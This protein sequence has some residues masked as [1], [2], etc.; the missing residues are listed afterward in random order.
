MTE[1]NKKLHSYLLSNIDQ[2]DVDFVIPRLGVDIP[3]GID[4]FLLFKSRDPWLKE[5]HR[6][7][8]DFFNEGIRSVYRNKH[9][10]PHSVFDFPEPPEV[11]LGYSK[12]SK[13]GS[14][15]TNNLSSL[16]I[17][18]LKAAPELQERGIR[19]IEEMQLLSI[20]IGPDR[21][22]D[23]TVNVLKTALIDYTQRQ[24]ELWDIKLTKDVPVQHVLDLERQEW[25]DG[26][27]NLPISPIDRTPIILVPRRIVR[28]L[29]WINYDDFVKTEFAAYLRAK[30][31]KRNFGKK[32]LMPKA[33]K[34]EVTEISCREIERVDRYI[35]KKEASA[36]DAQPSC[37]Y[38]GDR[39]LNEQAEL[40][41]K[42]LQNLPLGK[43]S[44]HQF[45]QLVLEILNYLF[46]PELIDGRLEVRTIDG[47][48]RR[49]IIFT[50]DSDETF[51]S[52]L[53]T[54]HSS[55]LLMFE[56]KNKMSVSNNDVAQ[57][58]T[59]LGD[60]IGR[61]GFIVMRSRVAEAQT[62]KAFSVYN[63]SHPRKVILFINDEDLKYMLSV[64][65]QGGNPMKYLQKIYR[66]FR[67]TVQ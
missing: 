16:I 41:E 44:A 39:S 62:R 5:I 25:F 15:V 58:A 14:G 57:V 42:R 43:E 59:Y 66:D 26:Y 52:Y 31:T 29:P 50:N 1:T 9:H 2:Y 18:T 61:I 13:R 55:I 10:D 8:V 56:A 47:T 21:I 53:R 22:S 11:G 67:T 30:Q 38:L 63:D 28:A 54:E 3:V 49:D 60:R 32:I 40:L 24:C 6:T 19:H 33:S 35:A 36:R 48:E 51:W 23:I 12:N 34:K 27:Y 64:R 37:E 7:L 45:Q 65:C 46:N 20:G 4:P 17:N